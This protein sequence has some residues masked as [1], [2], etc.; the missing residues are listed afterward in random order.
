MTKY[1]YV[2]IRSRLSG[3]F[4]FDDAFLSFSVVRRKRISEKFQS[5]GD[6]PLFLNFVVCKVYWKFD[7][8]WFFLNLGLYSL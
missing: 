1:F 3:P 4:E 6:C 7:R 5:I 2:P 8:I